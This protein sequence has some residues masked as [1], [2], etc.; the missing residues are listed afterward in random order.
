MQFNFLEQHFFLMVGTT[1][2][3]PY[4]LTPLLCLQDDDPSRGQI[5]SS[6][7]FVSGIVTLMQTTLG[8]RPSLENSVLQ[9]SI[10][11]HIC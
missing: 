3:I 5:I 6:I 1:L 10:V 9:S 8:C 2:P 11:Y 4:V 7:L